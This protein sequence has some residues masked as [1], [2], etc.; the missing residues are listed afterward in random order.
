MAHCKHT[1]VFSAP[2]TA[3]RSISVLHVGP[4]NEIFGG[5]SQGL[6]VCLQMPWKER[7][8]NSLDPSCERP[9]HFPS[10]LPWTRMM[11][12]HSPCF[13]ARSVLVPRQ[14]TW[15]F[16]WW[17]ASR[18]PTSWRTQENAVTHESSDSFYGGVLAEVFQCCRLTLNFFL[19]SCSFF[20]RSFC[21]FFSAS[22]RFLST[23]SSLAL[24]CLCSAASL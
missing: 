9:S 19:A 18:G 1:N 14:S 21:S 24:S 13:R 22:S 20:S 5:L 6:A 4:L 12:R 23:L 8:V 2:F 7:D 11:S 10:G 17:T 3:H 16:T 15:A